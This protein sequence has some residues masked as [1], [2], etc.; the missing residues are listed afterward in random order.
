[1][2]EKPVLSTR[3]RRLESI[4]ESS[5]PDDLR[6]YQKGYLLLQ[7]LTAGGHALAK[8]GANAKLTKLYRQNL[9]LTAAVANYRRARLSEQGLIRTTKLAGSEQYELTPDGRDYLVSC[10]QYP[11]FEF[12][13]TGKALNALLACAKESPFTPEK[14]AAP[15][16]NTVQLEEA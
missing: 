16:P 3:T 2:L 5:I 13:L 14:P 11:E 6:E 7:L 1:T 8:K 12:R 15:G 4:D 10:E 9:G